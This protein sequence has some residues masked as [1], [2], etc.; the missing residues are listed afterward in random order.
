MKFVERSFSESP[1]NNT[2]YC[3]T[4]R[5]E[6]ES[7]TFEIICVSSAHITET[8]PSHKYNREHFNCIMY[9]GLHTLKLK[10]NKVI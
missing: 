7:T 10:L 4:V 1:L 8:L 6:S 5:F 3:G 9:L 2:S